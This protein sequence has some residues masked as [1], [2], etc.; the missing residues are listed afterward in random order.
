VR[1]IPGVARDTDERSAL[2]RRMKNF[3]TDGDAVLRAG[4]DRHEVAGRIVP[5]HERI[6]S[7][8]ICSGIGGVPVAVGGAQA[9]ARTSGG[10]WDVEAAGPR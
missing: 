1:I 4:V 6:L 2:D 5:T 7:A 10:K 3:L 9:R 8:V